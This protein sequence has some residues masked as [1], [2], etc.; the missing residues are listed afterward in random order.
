MPV[1]PPLAA[2]DHDAERPHRCLDKGYDCA[3]VRA[4]VQAS[5]WTAHIPARAHASPVIAQVVT[6]LCPTPARRR[7]GTTLRQ[8]QY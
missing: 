5:A 1:A 8:G 2:A 7:A 6:G 3:E 4:Q